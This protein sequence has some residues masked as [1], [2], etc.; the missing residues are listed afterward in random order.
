MRSLSRSTPPRATRAASCICKCRRRHRAL[1]YDP[2]ETHVVRPVD[3]VRPVSDDVIEILVAEIRAVVSPPGI[4]IVAPERGATRQARLHAEEDDHADLVGA[5][6]PA[7]RVTAL[8]PLAGNERQVLYDLR[9]RSETVQSS[10]WAF[11]RRQF[12]RNIVLL[13]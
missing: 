7:R 11:L 9:Q 10:Q 5:V 13:P 1:R 3:V 8:K 6:R 4:F 2:E 12:K